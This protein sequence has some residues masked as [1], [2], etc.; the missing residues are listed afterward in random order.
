VDSGNSQIRKA[1]QSGS[2][3][4]FMWK[5]GTH[6]SGNGEFDMPSG[7]AVASDGSIYVADTNNHR[8][9]RFTSGGVFVSKWGTNGTGDGQFQY[10]A[11][12]AIA[13]DGSVYVVDTDNNRIQ[14][15]S[16]GP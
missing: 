1:T 12:V 3:P 4:L 10:P 7:I 9:Q 16:V 14:K 2:A 5:W 13:S 6:G 15:F 8:I 11:G